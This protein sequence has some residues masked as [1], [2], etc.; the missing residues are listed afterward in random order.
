VV[1]HIEPC[2]YHEGFGYCPIPGSRNG[3]RLN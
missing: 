2:D 1:I 3:K